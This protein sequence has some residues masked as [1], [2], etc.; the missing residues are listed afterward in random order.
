MCGRVHVWLYGSVYAWARAA[1]LGLW[2]CVCV[3]VCMCGSCCMGL[4]DCV[5]MD[6]QCVCVCV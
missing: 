4:W 1:R 3:G 6:C 2:E 5:C